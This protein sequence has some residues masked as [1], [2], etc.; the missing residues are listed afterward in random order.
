MLKGQGILSRRIRGRVVIGLLGHHAPSLIA[1]F[2]V[3]VAVGLLGGAYE[4]TIRSAI[5]ALPFLA[6]PL[7]TRNLDV[8]DDLR[9]HEALATV[10]V[11]F[12]I[13]AL[14][15][16]WPFMAY[17]LSPLD[18]LFE[19]MSGVTSTGFSKVVDIE[20]WP[21]PAQIARA[22]TQWYGG[23]VILSV[24]VALLMQPG[25][26]IQRLGM[27]SVRTDNVIDQMNRRARKVLLVYVIV[28]FVAIA[29]AWLALRDV[30]AA[31]SLALAA[32]STGGFSIYNDSVASVPGAALAVIAF[33]CILTAIPVDRLYGLRQ[34]KFADLFL[35]PEVTALLALA[36]FG[37]F[38]LCVLEWLTTGATS[39]ARLGDLA[40][41]AVSAQTTAGF[42]ATEVGLLASSQ[43]FVIIGMMIIGGALGST[44]GGIKVFRFLALT[45]VLREDLFKTSVGPNTITTAR[46]STGRIHDSE[47]D[48]AVATTLLFVGVHFASILVLSAQGIPLVDAA[49]D[50]V[51]A[52][53][54]VG[55][56]T[57][58]AGPEASDL[59]T[60]VIIF[61]MWLGRLEILAVVV[62]LN[63]WFWIRKG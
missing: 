41:N 5:C 3:P 60:A 62:L 46:V 51:S 26:T 22:W 34:R 7:F 11:V 14:G 2:V 55:L 42:A 32:V 45:A 63:P 13:A 16:T 20:A 31:V 61:N 4:F 33:F 17:G 54:T 25:P 27:L 43:K 36:A 15:M 9:T 52:V 24:V 30:V 47:I 29:L 50:V 44:A 12:A 1:L 39:L 6:L 23:F 59:T 18:A 21:W 38:A 58:V 28:T 53:S 19:A 37:A 57:G 56:S 40:F 10:A 48:G 49:F 35:H 8:P